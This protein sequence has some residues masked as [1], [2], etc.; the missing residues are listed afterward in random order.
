MTDHA[1]SFKTEA[2]YTALRTDRE[3]KHFYD[4]NLYSVAYSTLTYFSEKVKRNKKL[5]F[6]S[7]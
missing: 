6:K 4:L 3:I 1:K 2:F 5:I 7:C